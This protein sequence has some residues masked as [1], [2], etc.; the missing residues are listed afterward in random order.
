MLPEEPDNPTGPSGDDPRRGCT[1]FSGIGRH[2]LRYRL[3]PLNIRTLSHYALY[4][5][6]LKDFR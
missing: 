5:N 2:S 6:T 4:K 3:R 1:K